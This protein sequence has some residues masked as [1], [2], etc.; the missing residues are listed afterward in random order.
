MCTPPEGG[1]KVGKANL[2]RA[3]ARERRTKTALNGTPE[4][5]PFQNKV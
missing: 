1:E 5:V 3:E 4:A 2:S